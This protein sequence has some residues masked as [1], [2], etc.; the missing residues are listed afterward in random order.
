MP[1]W[2]P[3]IIVPYWPFW[4][5]AACNHCGQT[6]WVLVYYWICVDCWE[7]V[8]INEEI[9]AIREWYELRETVIKAYRDR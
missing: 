1:P 6:D 9:A 7:E 3:P 8:R 2:T 4:T 5:E